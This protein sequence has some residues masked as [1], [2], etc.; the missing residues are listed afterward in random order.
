MQSNNHSAVDGR[1]LQ[2][3]VNSMANEK[4][5]CANI[6]NICVVVNQYMQLMNVSAVGGSKSKADS[7]M[8]PF[9]RSLPGQDAS[10]Q[11]QE[12]HAES[13]ILSPVSLF[14]IPFLTEIVRK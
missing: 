2:R 10:L 7:L 6:L 11:E 4:R 3:H 9:V 13:K 1:N 5:L 8:K 14:R 12:L